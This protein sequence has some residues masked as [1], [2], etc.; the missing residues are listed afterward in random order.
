MSDG[1]S[2]DLQVNK[3]E[4]LHAETVVAKDAHYDEAYVKRT[5]RK[6]DWRILPLLGLL[7]SI[8]LID[9]TNLGIA[10]IAGMNEDLGLAIGERYSIASMVYF[11]PYI[12]LQLPSNIVLRWLGAQTW[13]TIC[14]IG[15]AF[16]PSW[17]LLCLTR[18]L[19]GVFEAGFFPALAFIIQ[20]WYKR[21]EVQ[22]RLAGF[23]LISIVL[24]GFSAILAYAFQLLRG[25]GGLNGWQWIFLLEGIITIVVGVLTWL[26][27]PDFPDRNRFLKP[28][29]TKMILDRVEADRGDSVPDAINIKVI[30][31]HLSDP[32]LWSFALLFL[33]STMPA[34]AIGFFITILLFGMGF[35]VVEALTLSAPPYV[36]AAISCFFFAWLSD[37]T[38][39]RA[40]WL[41]VQSLIT[42]TGLMI[43]G[44]SSANGARYFGLFLVNMGASG[45]VPGVLAYNANNVTSHSKRSVSTAVI[46]AFGGIG[47]IFATLVFRQQDAPSYIPGIWAT[48]ACQFMM[49]I[50]LAINTGKR[51][52]EGQPGFYY[53]I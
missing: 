9:R 21:D 27:V 43:T 5:M 40:L 53:T 6:V 41:G 4:K 20:T 3:S 39:K 25:K 16:V 12:I 38:K 37:K 8:A 19:L 14:V 28:E 36:A 2:S 10:R 11:P 42:L 45:C 34:Y 18:V 35:N 47:G 29:D 17:G 32:F 50:L 31:K 48:A 13:L 7:Y 49:L 24:G 22:K 30:L 1:Q 15:M 44:Y 46:I 33:A 26:F 51:V 23:Y 52:N